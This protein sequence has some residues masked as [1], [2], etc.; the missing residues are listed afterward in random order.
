MSIG[1]ETMKHSSGHH[2]SFVDSN[3]HSAKHMAKKTKSKK[4]VGIVLIVLAALIVLFLGISVYAKN[5]PAVFPNTYLGNV[6]VGKMDK[7][8]LT[9]TVYSEY[10]QS[11]LNNKSIT[12]S[13]NGKSENFDLNN[14][15]T[16]FD[17]EAM[18]N[19]S[20]DFG[21]N[22]GLINSG[23][24]FIKSLFSKQYIK[25]VVT[26][27]RD[28]LLSAIDGI[29][30]DF[31][32]EP[33]NYTCEIKSDRLIIYSAVD[34]IK[35]NRE[36]AL[37]DFEKEVTNTTFNPIVLNPE[38]ISPPE[39]DT[40]ALC[41]ELNENPRD[42]YYEKI[43][44]K[45]TVHP[46]KS[47]CIIDKSTLENAINDLKASNK[48][49]IEIS[50]QTVIPENTT[51]KLSE[52]LYKDTLGK[53]STSY[54]GSSAARANNVKTAVSRLDGVELMPGDEFSYDKTIL[55]RTTQNG[56]MAAPVY[57]GNKVESGLGGGI[58]QP[59]STLYA[60]A[61][62]ANLEILERHNHSLKVG[63]LPSGLDATIAENSL[64]LRIRN[65]T[66]YP[67]KIDAKSDGGMI[68]VRILG[69][70]PE[71]ISADISITSNGMTYY[72]TRIVKKD[73]V[74]I[75]REKMTS[76]TYHEKEEDKPKPAEKPSSEKPT[77]PAEKPDSAQA[78]TV[79][80]K[81]E[82]PNPQ[83]VKSASPALSE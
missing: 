17:N 53:Y 28:T 27:D 5:L 61:L 31:E 7:A 62:Y 9:E 74:E 70:N 39:I 52:I 11:I 20:F 6:N 68:T 43:D 78:S 83:P 14:A 50:V 57:V 35:A 33:V 34:G 48:T 24:A 23:M 65:N 82:T 26:Y 1:R 13:C 67:V 42:A 81:P 80:P 45:V 69:Y 19:N 41:N 40:Q 36:A 63:Y 30:R 38:P 79:E 66:A 44:G 55:P 10:A 49:S 56:Y 60:A 25:P 51:E 16:A 46:S 32:K 71:K 3:K 2:K 72:V 29:T 73:G 22:D 64:D 12:L 4:A 37:S 15:K 21:K 8:K 59:S 76:S 47:K 58:C 75:S 54:G 77:T 18:I